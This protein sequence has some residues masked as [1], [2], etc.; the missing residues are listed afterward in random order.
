MTRHIRRLRLFLP[1]SI[2]LIL[3]VAALRPG[4]RASVGQGPSTTP[5]RAVIPNP[6]MVLP[7]ATNLRIQVGN[8]PAGSEALLD[9]SAGD[10][11]QAPPTSLLLNRTPRL[12]Q[13]EPIPNR[14]IPRCQVRAL[15]AGG[16]LF[17]RL[18]WEDATKNAPEAP[19]ARTGEGGDP[20]QLYKRPTGE[21]SAF[22]DA[23][24]VMVPEAWTGPA[25]PSLV[26]GD[27]NAPVHI[28]YWNA[29][30]GARLMKASGRATPQPT[31]QTIP[32]RSR[33]EN[34]QWVVTLELAD[35]PDGYPIAFAVWDGQFD[36]RDGLKCFSVWHVLT[37]K[38]DVK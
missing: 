30:R 7:P 1:A 36:D 9:L 13:T 16:K 20:K 21:P 32:H 3:L 14:P 19:P 24:A 37:K 15:R 17:V 23:A 28:A 29:S 27:K 12:Y 18:Q 26:M 31:G 2:F 4:G 25:F 6:A 8:S 34:A 38:G 5:D 33:H 22:A 35:L 10:W 11:N